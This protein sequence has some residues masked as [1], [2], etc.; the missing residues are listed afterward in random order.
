MIG[1]SVAPLPSKRSQ[2]TLPPL[3]RP[4]GRTDH[5]APPATPQSPRPARDHA[6]A[7]AI[8]S[9]R[10]EIGN[11]KRPD[12]VRLFGAA[13]VSAP[14][15]PRTTPAHHVRRSKSSDRLESKNSHTS[16]V[17][18]HPRFLFFVQVGRVITRFAGASLMLER[19]PRG[20]QPTV[21]GHGTYTG[22]VSS[23]LPTT[24]RNWIS[25]PSGSSTAKLSARYAS[26]LPATPTVDLL[27]F[28]KT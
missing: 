24:I 16:F 27:V 26:S 5:S 19:I 13:R 20:R 7:R 2:S 17:T 11:L 1:L 9:L 28:S 14:P 6:A 4:R 23:R 8:R 10:P 22:L 25:A 12:F 18:T 21:H 15:L 3:K